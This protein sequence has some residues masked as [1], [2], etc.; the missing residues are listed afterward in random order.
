MGLLVGLSC[1]TTVMASPQTPRQELDLGLLDLNNAPYRYFHLQ[2]YPWQILDHR[3]AYSDQ[4]RHLPPWQLRGT[5]VL[6]KL[7]P[8]TGINPPLLRLRGLSE[9]AYRYNIP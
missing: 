4:T 5:G 8:Y 9:Q 3:R 7:H 6:G 2:H 1:G